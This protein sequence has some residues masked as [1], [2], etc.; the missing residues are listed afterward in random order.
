VRARSFPSSCIISGS[1]IRRTFWSA[2]RRRSGA[3][4]PVRAKPRKSAPASSFS[5]TNVECD[6]A[7]SRSGYDGAWSGGAKRTSASKDPPTT[8]LNNRDGLAFAAHKTY[9][10]DPC[11]PPQP[12]HSPKTLDAAAAADRPLSTGQVWSIGR[13]S[14]PAAKMN[15]SISYAKKVKAGP[16]LSIVDRIAQATSGFAGADLANLVKQKRPAAR[17]TRLCALAVEQKDLK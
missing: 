16:R 2:A 12:K 1:R 5:L 4:K 6:P 10:G 13:R 9:R 14:S 3:L 15:S 11:W 8:C 7:K 17:G